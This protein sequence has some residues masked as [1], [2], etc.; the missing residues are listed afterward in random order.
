MVQGQNDA[1][2][3]C[4]RVM[5]QSENVCNKVVDTFMLHDLENAEVF[6]DFALKSLVDGF[7]CQLSTLSQPCP[8]QASPVSNSK[9]SVTLDCC[10][11]R[12]IRKP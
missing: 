10:W 11:A 1:S 9:A 2:S 3:P 8:V 12:L 7:T 6:G 4:M 5:L